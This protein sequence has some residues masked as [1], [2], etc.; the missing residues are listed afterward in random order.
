MSVL[1][2]NGYI[3]I[4]VHKTGS[5][6]CTFSIDGTL[7]AASQASSSSLI[8]PVRYAVLGSSG[9]LTPIV[10][11]TSLGAGTQTV[12]VTVLDGFS[13]IAIKLASVTGTVSVQTRA[14]V[15]PL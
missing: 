11:A 14:L 10:T 8:S 9:D 7:D 3:N 12:W 1:G 2:V 15:V 5:G 13:A 6:T 4:E